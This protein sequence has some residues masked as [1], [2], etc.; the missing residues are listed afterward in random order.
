MK[1]KRLPALITAVSVLLSCLQPVCAM[2][3]TG[4]GKSLTETCEQCMEHYEDFLDS[5][6]GYDYLAD[7]ENFT[8][9]RYKDSMEDTAGWILFLKDIC[10]F[11]MG[12][13]PDLEECMDA[14][15][16][17][18]E[19]QSAGMTDSLAAQ[20]AY[21]VEKEFGEYVTDGVKVA[22]SAVCAPEVKKDLEGIKASLG[23][24]GDLL[25]WSM[26]TKE[27]IEAFYGLTCRY[28][29]QK[30]FLT[31]IRDH[32]ENKNLKKA[33]EA[34]LEMAQCQLAYYLEQAKTDAKLLVSVI[35]DAAP[36]FTEEMISWLKSLGTVKSL[37]AALGGSSKFFGYASSCVSKAAKLFGSVML[38][39]DIGAFLGD[40]AVG[41]VYRY[42][43][44]AE[45]MSDI[46]R[47]LL[48]ALREQDPRQKS[49]HA[50]PHDIHSVFPYLQRTPP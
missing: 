27:N 1:K 10:D 20:S 12:T 15:I 16:M 39:K 22:A 23:I 24:S 38:A 3:D 45:L 50:D 26:D 35:K 49:C 41:N 9:E 17:L 4:D 18:L 43:N 29:Y 13:N 36:V 46:S 14:L 2:A 7:K 5:P 30:L 42:G 31:A 6:S 21:Q 34:L 33:A 32:T 40:L 37:G 47:A 25:S 48:A 44:E 19:M 8:Y 11:S 28:E